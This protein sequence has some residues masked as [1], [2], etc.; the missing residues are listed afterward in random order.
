MNWYEPGAS[1]IVPAGGRFTILCSDYGGRGRYRGDVADRFSFS[2]PDRRGP[3]DPWFRVG[4]IEFGTAAVFSALCAVSMVIYGFEPVDKPFLTKLA[5]IPSEVLDGQIWRIVTW[6]FANGFDERLFWIVVTIALLWYFGGR[7]EEQVGRT[8]FGIFLVAVIVLP[9]IAGTLLDLP[10][11]GCRSVQLVVLLVFVAEYPNVRF[12]FGIPAWALGLVYV[13]TDILQLTGARAGERLLFY[14]IS[15]AIAAVAARSIGLLAAYPW[16]PRVPIG[17]GVRTRPARQGEGAT[18]I[19]GRAADRRR[20]A[21]GDAVSRPESDVARRSGRARLAARQDRRNGDGFTLRRREATPQRPVEEA[22]QA[23]THYVDAVGKFVGAADRFRT[24]AADVHVVTSSTAII[25]VAAWASRWKPND[26]FTKPD[27][28]AAT[29]PHRLSV[30]SPVPCASTRDSAGTE[31][32]SNVV[33]AIRHTLHPS[34]SRNRPTNIIAGTYPATTV[35]TVP[36]ES[37]TAPHAT[38]RTVPTRTTKR[39]TT[40]DS[41]NM[42]RMCTAITNADRSACP[43]SFMCAGVIVIT[44]TIAAWAPAIDASP[45]TAP[46]DRRITPYDACTWRNGPW[47]LGVRIRGAEHHQ[48]IGAQAREHHRRAHQEQGRA[49]HI[50]PDE[51]VEADP[52]GRSPSRTA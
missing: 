10:Q 42:P 38:A 51:L 18:A 13:I 43:W 27:P 17:D 32:V 34:P 52:V 44:A 39:P 11:A 30:R 20:R 8:K 49:E 23:L 12:F 48:W 16:I 33:P 22:P 21:V 1:G 4:Q 26:C 31:P 15:L 14:V 40:G 45:S 46:G 5:L 2:K 3:H 37:T 25:A 6:P 7:L 9:G 24:R 19:E 41:P 50:R 47:T 29:A 35:A 36:D 28:N